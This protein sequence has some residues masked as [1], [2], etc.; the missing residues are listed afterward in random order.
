MGTVDMGADEFTSK[1]P[2][3]INKFTVKSGNSCEIEFDLNA[4]IENAGQGYVLLASTSGT[5][6]G[7]PLPQGMILRLEWDSFT[8]LVLE[9]MNTPI[10]NDFWGNQ[11]TLTTTYAAAPQD[12]KEAIE[13]IRSRKINVKDMITHRLELAEIAKGFQLVT[14]ARESIKVIIKP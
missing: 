9:Y 3:E 4:G 13:L 1:H 8:E 6:P 12:I 14:D 10:F 7:F 5:I 11:L 2:L